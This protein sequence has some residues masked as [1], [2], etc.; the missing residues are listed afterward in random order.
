MMVLGS[1]LEFI[2]TVAI[3]IIIAFFVR[4]Y[5]VQPF[6]V[7]GQSMEPNFHNGQYL[8]V[9][10]LTYR[11]R[12]PSRGDVIVFH[13]PSAPNL[14]YIKRIIA[15]PGDEIEIKNGE[16]FVNGAMID[17]PYIPDEKTLVR[18]PRMSN[19]LKQKL[20]NEEYFVLGDNRDHSSDS[21]E[22]GVLPKANII[23]RTWLI[24][25]PRP[26]IVQHQKYS[27]VP[28]AVQAAGG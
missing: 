12:L 14:N 6:V 15:L 7:E 20:G 9:D 28:L 2:K 3:I 24:V 26:G 22:W 17:E 5:L 13:P 16:I 19:V 21:R 18:N 23:G 8:M 11:F 4:F 27:N 10:K 1:I 25:Y